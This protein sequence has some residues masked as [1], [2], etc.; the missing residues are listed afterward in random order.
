MLPL[1][2]DS[3]AVRAT[4][5]LSDLFG[6]ALLVGCLSLPFFLRRTTT[7]AFSGDRPVSGTRPLHIPVIALLLAL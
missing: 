7:H 1:S 5:G 3:L 4:I 6:L 2:P